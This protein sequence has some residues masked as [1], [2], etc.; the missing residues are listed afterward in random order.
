MSAGW[1]E[2]QSHCCGVLQCAA[3]GCSGSTG[4]RNGVGFRGERKCVGRV[5]TVSA[6]RD[7]HQGKTYDR[8]HEQTCSFVALTEAERDTCDGT[9]QK[10]PGD[11]QVRSYAE[12]SMCEGGGVWSCDRQ[13]EGADTG[14]KRGGIERAGSQIRQTNC[15]QSDGAR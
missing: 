6:A 11:R 12:W 3:A 2:K 10:C 13:G 8:N 1:R 14:R 9:Y 7:E 15:G 4:D 5:D